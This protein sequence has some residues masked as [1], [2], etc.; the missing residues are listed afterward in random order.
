MS[1]KNEIVID[2]VKYIREQTS[3][4]IRIAILHRGF[5][6][7]GRFEQD[8][9]NCVLKNA[10]NVRRWGT[11]A[12]LGELAEKGPLNK[13]KLDKCPN[14]RFHELGVINFIDCCE[15]SWENVI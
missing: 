2:G 3:N 4:D 6:Y 14:V 13:T 12:G 11:T 8:G 7:V 15:E 1:V 5:V 10:Y 9:P